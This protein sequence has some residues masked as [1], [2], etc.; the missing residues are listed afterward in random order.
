MKN[1]FYLLSLTTFLSIGYFSDNQT[2]MAEEESTCYTNCQTWSY[3]S[4]FEFGCSKANSMPQSRF[5]SL[6]NNYLHCCG[7]TNYAAGFLEGYGLC[8]GDGSADHVDTSGGGSNDGNTDVE[9]DDTVPGYY[10]TDKKGNIISCPG[11]N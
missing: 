1:F 4:G 3:Q 2:I 9:N 11:G 6:Y 8:H 5:T 10:C 7:C